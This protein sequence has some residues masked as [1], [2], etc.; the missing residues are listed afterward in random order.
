MGRLILDRSATR[1]ASNPF[2]TKFIRPGAIDFIFD[3]GAALPE[4]F[5]RFERFGLRGQI[6]GPHGCGKSTLLWALRRQLEQNAAIHWTQVQPRGEC[7]R[8]P[9]DDLCGNNLDWPQPNSSRDQRVVWVV[10]GF[11][12][13]GLQAI[14]HLRDRNA[15]AT[16]YGFRT[17]LP[18]CRPSLTFAAFR[19]L[20]LQLLSN[21]AVELNEHDIQNS[22]DQHFPN[23]REALFALY[24]AYERQRLPLIKTP[25]VG[26]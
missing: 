19:S 25:A 4:I 22:Y 5:A 8:L 1:S 24:D 10:D 16:D 20:V 21:S 23:A 14:R 9:N 18:R 26:G 15:L 12:Q 11:D 7:N 13:A 6:V 2:S 3:R 17:K